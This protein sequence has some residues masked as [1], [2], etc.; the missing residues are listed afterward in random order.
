MAP[1][2]ALGGSPKIKLHDVGAGVMPRRPP[3]DQAMVNP[4]LS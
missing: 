1:S 3:Y 2:P 4:P